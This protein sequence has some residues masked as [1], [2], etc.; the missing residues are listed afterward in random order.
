MWPTGLWAELEP[1]LLLLL[2]WSSGLSHGGE[3]LG[4]GGRGTQP[5]GVDEAT[6]SPAV[7]TETEGGGERRMSAFR[8]WFSPPTVTPCFVSSISTVFPFSEWMLSIS[9]KGLPGW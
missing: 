7:S 1:L 6:A 9:G 5:A 8:F 2:F 4:S 3:G